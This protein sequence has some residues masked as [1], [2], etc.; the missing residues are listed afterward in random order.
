MEYIKLI[1]PI[2]FEAF[3]YFAFVFLV[4]FRGLNS[5]DPLFRTISWVIMIS[6]GWIGFL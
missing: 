3:L 4:Y 6:F 1:L 2:L 5:E